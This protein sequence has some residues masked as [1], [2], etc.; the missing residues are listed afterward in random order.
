MKGNELLGKER[1]HFNLARL[2]AGGARFEVIIDPDKAVGFKGGSVGDVR[3]VLMYEK[4]FADARKG[5]LA[6]EHDMQRAFGTS[7]ALKVAEAVLSRGEIQV[8]S[9]YRDSVRD[10]RVRQVIQLIHRN[11]V[12]PRSGFSH[13]VKRIEN[14]FEEAKVRI[15]ERKSAEAQLDDVVKKLRVVLPLRFETRQVQVVVPS[16]FASKAEGIAKG[17]GRLVKESWQSDGTLFAVLELPAGLQE[18]F[19]GQL[20]ALT[21]GDVDI[22]VLEGSAK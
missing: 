10:A 14:A 19:S 16:R 5:Q 11:S 9:A 1:A 6:S 8:T 18:E 17:Y 15:D 21:H 2:D 13:P 22:K 7:D 4:V 3:E 12:D 20:N